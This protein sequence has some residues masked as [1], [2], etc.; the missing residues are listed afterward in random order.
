MNDLGWS[1]FMV[2]E[3]HY[4]VDTLCKPSNVEPLPRQTLSSGVHPP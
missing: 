3:R 1:D 4:S 2:T